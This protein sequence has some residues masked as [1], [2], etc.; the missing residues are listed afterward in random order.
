[1]LVFGTRWS[2]PLIDNKLG[3]LGLY[4]ELKIDTKSQIYFL[5]TFWSFPFFFLFSLS[6]F[7][8]PLSFPFPNFQQNIGR[9]KPT[10]PPPLVMPMTSSSVWERTSS[11]VFIIRTDVIIVCDVII[12]LRKHPDRMWNVTAKIS[13]CGFSRELLIYLTDKLDDLFIK[14]L[15]HF[16]QSGTSAHLIEKPTCWFP[17]FSL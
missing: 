17:D 10:R 3:G 4:A 12:S 1:M 14:I 8:F 2:T 5:M 13:K 11:S 15:A 6:S 7:L 16:T 9:P